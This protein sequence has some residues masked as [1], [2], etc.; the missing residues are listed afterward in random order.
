VISF[1]YL[2]T[3]TGNVPLADLIVHDDQGT[4]Q[5]PLDDIQVCTLSN[6]LEDQSQSC[7]ANHTVAAGALA[8]QAGV[9]GTAPV[10]PPVVGSDPA[11]LYG[12]RPD[13][14]IGM[15]LLTNEVDVDAPPGVSVWVSDPVTWTYRI[16]NFTALDVEN[17]SV[18][19]DNGT[20]A[21]PVDDLAVCT[22]GSLPPL[23]WTT[24]T[25]SAPAGLGQYSNTATASAIFNNE[26]VSESD[27]SY[28]YGKLRTLFLPLIRR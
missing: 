26:P 25:R 9:S 6:L 16:Y 7:Q 1:T 28:Y 3:N 18:Q 17:I 22:I 14:V 4:P 19:D 11:Y 24:C 12:Y 21:N 10:G 15:Q 2:V 23:S 20:P 27:L 5:N 13:Q 8:S